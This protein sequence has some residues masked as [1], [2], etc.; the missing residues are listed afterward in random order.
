VGRPPVTLRTQPLLAPTALVAHSPMPT[1]G[2]VHLHD[3]GYG[4]RRPHVSDAL[5]YLKNG[6]VPELVI[7]DIR[8]PDLPGPKLGRRL[9]EQYPRIPVLFVSGRPWEPAST[10]RLAAHSN[11]SSCRSHSGRRRSSPQ[12][13]ACSTTPEIP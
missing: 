6:R 7:L 2:G 12:W 11:G 4:D 1:R 13:N 8:I 10:D 9:H 3:R 5:T